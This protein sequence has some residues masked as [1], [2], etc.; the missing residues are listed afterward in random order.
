[1]TLLGALPMTAAE[2][3]DL[4]ATYA[5]DCLVLLKRPDGSVKVIRVPAEHWER[6]VDLAGGEFADNSIQ[7]GGPEIPKNA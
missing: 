4:N 6:V 7:L 1:M 5:A 3:R 2:L